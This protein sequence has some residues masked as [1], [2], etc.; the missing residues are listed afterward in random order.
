MPSLQILA[1]Q[2]SVP[3]TPDAAARDAHLD[4]LSGLLDE[5]LIQERTDLVV[6]PE[7]SSIDY[8][9][10]SFDN[11]AELAEPLDGP[12]FQALSPIA[13]EHRCH[14][15]YGFPRIAGDRYRISHNLIGPDGARAGHFD[16]LHLAQYGASMEKEYFDEGEALFLF[17]VNGVKLAPIICY[18]IRFPGLTRALCQ[19]H[20]AQVVLHVGAYYT[21]ESYWSWY[22]FVVAR[23]IEN[24]VFLLSL[25]RAGETYGGSM[26]CS[27]WVDE[28]AEP[29]RYP[30]EETLMRFHIDTA[31]IDQVRKDYTFVADAR[32][33]YTTLP[34]GAP[35]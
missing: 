17:D 34:L 6:L 26:F 24:Q 30:K 25:N 9:R 33:D 22:H 3:P 28:T 5:A 23:A 18:D 19:T 2:I 4:R 10:E 21:D 8:S 15:L 12:T 29:V 20:G 31:Q 27:P 32:P 1:A 11:L 7:L 16:K 14:I 35:E 13:S